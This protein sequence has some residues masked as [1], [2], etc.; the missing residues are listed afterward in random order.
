MHMLHTYTHTY[1]HIFYTLWRECPNFCY[2]RLSTYRKHNILESAL[3]HENN[4]G[5]STARFI[6]RRRSGLRDV[7]GISTHGVARQ[8]EKRFYGR[9]LRHHRVHSPA[10]STSAENSHPWNVSVETPLTKRRR[11][12]SGVARICWA[13]ALYRNSTSKDT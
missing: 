12:D 2:Y 3:S 1:T 5:Y 11:T 4:A 6:R 13:F 7:N 9:I 10:L 8:E